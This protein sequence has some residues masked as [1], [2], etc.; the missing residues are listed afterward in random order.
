MTHAPEAEDICFSILVDAP[1]EDWVT[2]TALLPSVSRDA[3]GPNYGREALVSVFARTGGVEAVDLA[4]LVTAMLP[5]ISRL[6]ASTLWTELEPALATAISARP[7]ASNPQAIQIK[8]YR[9][10]FALTPLGEPISSGVERVVAANLVLGLEAATAPQCVATIIGIAPTL[11]PGVIE[12]VAPVLVAAVVPATN[13]PWRVRAQTGLAGAM[14]KAGRSDAVSGL[15]PTREA[16]LA[17]LGDPNVLGPWTRVPPPAVDVRWMAAQVAA[18]ASPT[19]VAKATID[20]FGQ[21]AGTGATVEERT[22]LVLDVL[23]VVDDGSAWI[24]TMAPHGVDEPAL[25]TYVSG[26]ILAEP[27]A[28]RRSEFARNLSTLQPTSP[29]AQ[30]L[31]AELMVWL[32]SRDTQADFDTASRL[33]RAVGTKHRLGPKLSGAFE[34]AVAAGMKLPEGRARELRDSGIVTKRKTSWLQRIMFKK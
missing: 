29:R 10:L 30:H 25:V 26:R 1:P 11:S 16:V 23:G 3:D 2:W 34:A 22:G 7:W 9:A 20:V 8:V 19:A 24:E 27:K 6:D 4:A 21:W 13:E 15:L 5:A 32:L 31:V 12:V 17:A 14:R 28:T 33:V 18:A